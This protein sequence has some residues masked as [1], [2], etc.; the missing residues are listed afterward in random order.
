M[1]RLIR[2]LGNEAGLDEVSL[3]LRYHV[4]EER[5]AAVGALLV[6]CADES[7][8]ESS[9][10]FQMTFVEHL[11]P[12]IKFWN[13]APFRCSN[14][15]GR[16]EWG[17]LPIAEQHFA[18][19]ATVDAFKVIVVKIN[20]HVAVTVVGNRIHFG[21]MDRYQTQ[22][23]A[24]GA[25]HAMLDGLP[26]PFIGAL[27]EAFESE[28]VDR[29]AILRDPERVD[30]SQR[31]LF[32]ALINARIQAR[33]A[34]ADLQAYRPMTPTKYIIA[35]CVTLNR[36]EKDSELLCGYYVADCREPDEPAIYQGLGDDPLNYRVEYR[37]AQL[38]VDDDQLSMCRPARDHRNLRRRLLADH[39]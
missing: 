16:Y 31:A 4:E 14:L 18:L 12:A 6:T 3:A 36:Q 5:P 8:R 1:E 29:L 23:T 37:F 19:P 33:H 17:S 2:L 21:R 39:L 7:E 10:A 13:R 9:E 28:G 30:P 26:L 27:Q 35:A 32:A 11:L 25:L 22:S 38:R 34:L 20:A 24:C 15:G